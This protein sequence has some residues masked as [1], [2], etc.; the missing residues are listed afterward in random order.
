[1]LSLQAIGQKEAFAFVDQ[2]HRHHDPPTGWRWGVAVQDGQ[3]IVG[4]AVVGRPVAREFDQEQVAEVTRLCTIPL[5]LGGV[6]NAG[7]MLL[8]ACERAALGRGILAL[9]SYIQ[10]DTEHGSTYRAANWWDLYR[11]KGGDWACE[12]RPDAKTGEN[13]GPKVLYCSPRSI[14]PRT[15]RPRLRVTIPPKDTAQLRLPLDQPA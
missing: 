13:N 2:W 9:V 15:V 8:G 6:K 10:V 3:R 12:A 14:D 4:V 1:M 5:D 7:S 11:T